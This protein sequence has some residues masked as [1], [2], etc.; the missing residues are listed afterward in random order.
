MT[1]SLPGLKKQAWKLLSEYVRRKDA[2]EG[3]TVECFT[4]RALS[5]WKEVD[6]GHFVPGR[7]GSVL[8]DERICRPQCKRCNIFLRGNYHAYT[9]RMIDEVGREKVEEYL[10]LKN[11]VKKWSRSDLEMFIKEYKAKVEGLNGSPD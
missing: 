7:S 10:A 9:L 3:G 1:K 2:D 8:L 5:Y 11:Q 6:C 4:C